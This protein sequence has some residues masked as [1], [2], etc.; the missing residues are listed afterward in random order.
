MNLTWPS[1]MSAEQEA[2]VILWGGGNNDFSF[3]QPDLHID[4]CDEELSRIAR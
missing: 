1:A 2:D 3:L 4:E